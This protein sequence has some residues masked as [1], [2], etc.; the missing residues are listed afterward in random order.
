MTAPQYVNHRID[1]ATAIKLVVFAAFFAYG[2]FGAG[3]KVYLTSGVDDEP[4]TFDVLASKSLRMALI[5]GGIIGFVL[6]LSA[7]SPRFESDVMKA[8]R[9]RTLTF[10]SAGIAGGIIISLAAAGIYLGVCL[11]LDSAGVPRLEAAGFGGS[12]AGALLVVVG[13]MAAIRWLLPHFASDTVPDAA[14]ESSGRPT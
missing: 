10:T 4:P 8:L 5:G 2:G 14:P 1:L 7:A 11:V 12:A 13:Y 9:I 6:G 3:K